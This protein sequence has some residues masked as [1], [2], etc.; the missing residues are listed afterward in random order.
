MLSNTIKEALKQKKYLIMDGA[1]GT[2]LQAHG[3]TPND[4]PADF[5]L[6]RQDVLRKVHTAY[7]VAGADILLTATFGGTRYKLPAHVDVVDFNRTMARAARQAVAE[8]GQNRP[9]FVAGDIGPTGHFVQPLGD[10]SPADMVS[11]LREQVRGLVEGGV[12]LI[13]IE[14]QFDLAE[15]RAA[16]AAVRMESDVPLFVSMTFEQGLTLTGT[17][18]EIFA[19][20]MQNMGVDAIG[21]NCGA[22]PEQMLGVVQSLAASGMLVFAEPNAG[23]PELVDGETVFRLA[24]QP[25]AEKTL[26]LVQAGA[27]I[28]GGCCGTSPEHIRALCMALEH[29]DATSLSVA[30]PAPEGV[31]LT[32]RSSL[33]RLGGQEPIVL[34]G[35]RI[36]PTGKKA[37]SAEFQAGGFDLAMRYAAE[38]IEAGARVLD[39]NVGAPQVNEVAYLPALVERLVARF[40][41]PLSLDS[42]NA[43]ALAQALPWHP[44]SALINSISGEAGR[45]EKLGPLCRLWG[46][47]FVL[48]PLE[49]SSLPTSAAERIAVIQNLVRQA[50]ALGLARR[51]MVVDVL[52]LT[53]ASDASAPA[54][55]LD[56]LR[57]CR[58][59]GL[60]TTV[61]LSNISFGMPARDLVNATFLAMAAGAGLNSCIGNPAN[62]RLREAVDTANVLMGHDP[63]ARHFIASYAEWKPGAPASAVLGQAGPGGP[64]VALSLEQAVIKGEKESIVA[65]VQEELAQGAEPFALVRE[66]L[67]PAITEVGARYE[68]KEYFLPQLLRSAETMQTAFAFLKPL[69]EQNSD[70]STRKRVILLATVEGDIHDIGKNIVAL[71]LGNHGYEV[72]DLGKDVKAADILQAAQKHRAEIIG[73]SALMTT[74]MPRMEDTVR[75]LRE[76]GLGCRV[77][78]GG[79]V[80]TAEY[81]RSIGADGY[82]ADAVEAVRLAARLLE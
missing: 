8:A 72:I 79:A 9:L 3:M 18:P 66:R 29:A 48:L 24:P 71:L 54:Q 61:G 30:P 62:V 50:E 42:P 73:L 38:Q 25:F 69:L 32:S 45:M 57:W 20:T 74:T 36:N 23:L 59:N 55:C 26:A 81:A 34:F 27:H 70:Q 63:Q 22:G 35:E 37:L 31:C 13:L 56:T 53:A 75:L 44:G 40:Q 14:T 16:V 6:A 1:C 12:D 58:E 33:V 47:P 41:S 21:V 80:V 51:L 10:V 17:S 43:E 11:A 28:V 39:V 78:V 76:Q 5:C 60:A 46:S 68:R 67:I 49:G 77:M 82:A 2:M 4:S 7:A 65:L 64:A 19:A 15:V 52:A